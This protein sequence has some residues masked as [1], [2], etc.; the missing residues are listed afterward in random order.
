MTTYSKFAREIEDMSITEHASICIENMKVAFFTVLNMFFAIVTGMM[1]VAANASFVLWNKSMAFAGRVRT[2]KDYATDDD[3]LVRYYMLLRKRPDWFPMN[4]FIHKYIASDMNKPHNS[5]WA[6]FTI[7]LSG[8]YWEYIYT[9]DDNKKVTSME[10]YWRKPGFYQYVEASQMNR[11][12]LESN[13]ACWTLVIPF[14]R[15][16]SWKF[17]EE[18]SEP[19]NVLIDD[20]KTNPITDSGQ[21]NYKADV[22][23]FSNNIPD[24]DGKVFGDESPCETDN[25]SDD[26][27]EKE[28]QEEQGSI[29]TLTSMIFGS[30]KQE[31]QD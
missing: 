16:G 6:Y 31:K 29:S 20:S 18:K 4:I 1:F 24:I 3:H 12:E 2:I 26:T 14:A 25:G 28:E 13:N 27:D 19:Q 15:R 30:D 11:I 9:L 21:Q 22:A 10:Q 23:D 7:V 5:P 8:G 17:L